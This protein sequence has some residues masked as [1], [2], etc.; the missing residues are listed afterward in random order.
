MFLNAKSNRDSG[1]E[2]TCIDENNFFT[3]DELNYK[4]LKSDLINVPDE[5]R[6]DA[7]VP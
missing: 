7:I 5:R 1:Y 4:P 2:I 6:H 3:F